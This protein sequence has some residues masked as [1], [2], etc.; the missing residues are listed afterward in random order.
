MWGAA[1]RELHESNFMLISEMH[2]LLV[3]SPALGQGWELY[4]GLSLG[5]KW[6]QLWR[7]EGM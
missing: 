2:D 6:H 1:A 3:N 5:S 4:I 7:G